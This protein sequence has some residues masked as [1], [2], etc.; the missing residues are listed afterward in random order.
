VG[1]DPPYIPRARA[2]RMKP[3]PPPIRFLFAVVGC[4]AGVRAYQLWP[5]H[6]EIGAGEAVAA[7]PARPPAAPAALPPLAPSRYQPA[8]AWTPP[9]SRSGQSPD[10]WSPA[11]GMAPNPCR[12]TL[13]QLSVVSGV[14]PV[15]ELGAALGPVSAFDP[16]RTFRRHRHM[17]SAPRRSHGNN[18]PAASASASVPRLR[19]FDSCVGILGIHRWL[20]FWRGVAWLTAQAPSGERLRKRAQIGI[21]IAVWLIVWFGIYQIAF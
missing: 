1:Q 13:P 9:D 10:Y 2:G 14:S 17:F 3:P 16:L 5:E 18:D 20:R 11:A 19:A 4:W 7:A 15:E 21:C 6:A 8:I 12:L